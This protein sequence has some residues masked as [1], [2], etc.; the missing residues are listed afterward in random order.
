MTHGSAQPVNEP[1]SA[2][3]RY[4]LAHYGPLLT[5]QHLAEVMHTTPNGVRMALARQRQPFAVALGRTRQRLGRRIYFEARQVAAVI[6]QGASSTAC[7]PFAPNVGAMF[8]AG[9]VPAGLARTNQ[10]PGHGEER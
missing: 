3:H 4:L 7:E 9:V 10:T 2:T 1:I 8:A 5:L 6:D